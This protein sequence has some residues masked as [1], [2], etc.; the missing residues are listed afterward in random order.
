M[1]LSP[2]L[3]HPLT[4]LPISSTLISSRSPSNLMAR[5][6]LA[7]LGIGADGAVDSGEL[8]PPPQPDKPLPETPNTA[9]RANGFVAGVRP[10]KS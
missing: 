10:S 9:R 5:Q 1:L 8:N 2:M 7:D 4:Y 6:D 3:L